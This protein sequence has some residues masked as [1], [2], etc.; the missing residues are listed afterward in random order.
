MTLLKP[1]LETNK[2]P[3]PTWDT[4]D[5]LDERNQ[6]TASPFGKY[7]SVTVE[8]VK[9]ELEGKLEK[10]YFEKGCLVTFAI[11]DKTVFSTFVSN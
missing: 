11:N 1:L 9:L 7:K 10:N 8:S 6:E 5:P 3:A 2:E 4:T